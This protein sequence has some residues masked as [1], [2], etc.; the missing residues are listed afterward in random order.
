MRS[1]I[2]RAL[3]TNGQSVWQRYRPLAAFA[4]IFLSIAFL[5]RLALLF[6][7]GDEVAQAAMGWP[8]IFAVGFG[9]DLLALIYL[10]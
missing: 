10:S 1:V 7:T 3:G 5:T 9:Y 8:R 2:Y 6:A 4:V